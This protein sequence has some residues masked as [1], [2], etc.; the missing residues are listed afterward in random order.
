MEYKSVKGFSGW[1]QFGMLLVFLG[2]AFVVAGIVQTVLLFKILPEG[3]SLTEMA[4][5]LEKAMVLPENMVTLQ[6]SQVV[7]TFLLFFLPAVLF[8]IVV[9]GKNPFWIG[10][11]PYLK[12][13]QLVL[14]FAIIFLANVAAGPLADLSKTILV[15]F[16]SIDAVA[17]KLE[18]AYNQQVM[19]MSNLSSWP[20]YIVAVFII[21]FF[22]AV[23]EEVLFRGV[24]Q[25]LLVRW[26]R[27]PIAGILVASILFS[28]IHGSI[29]L[30]ATRIVLG[31]VLGVIYYKSK[32]I[33]VNIIAH[34]LNNA[35]AVSQLFYMNKTTGKIDLNKLD[36]TIPWWAAL[37]ATSAL[38]FL[39]YLFSKKSLPLTAKIDVKE[40]VLLAKADPFRGI[41]GDVNV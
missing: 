7:G 2:L 31:I 4:A 22:P 6:I 29:Y 15:N 33:W 38:V 27:S 11:N 1:S 5:A 41:A 14:A 20:Q 10:F 9:H 32:N 19:A 30:F 18:I 12:P 40:K 16:P 37:L 25:N 35:L 8:T 13:V 3:T 26:W 34:F 17:K 21:A 36:V 24:L 39:F 28:V 23:F